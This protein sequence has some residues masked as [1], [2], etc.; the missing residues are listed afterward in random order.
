MIKPAIL[1]ASAAIFA[2]SIS[3]ASAKTVK[4]TFEGFCDGVTLKEVSGVATGTHTGSGCGGGEGGYAGGFSAKKVLGSVDTEWVVTTTDTS[5]AAGL[6]ELF[7]IDQTAMTWKLY[8]E[9]GK[10]A[11]FAYYSSGTLTEGVPPEAASRI[12]ALRSAGTTAAK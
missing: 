8:E 6:I 5:G 9:T 4:Y 1:A 2:C 12:E 10:S 3:P 11:G 7:T